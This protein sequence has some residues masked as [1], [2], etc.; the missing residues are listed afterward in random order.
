LGFLSKHRP[1]HKATNCWENH[2]F[3]AVSR[4]NTDQMAKIIIGVMGPGTCTEETRNL[5]Y[6]LGEAIASE[7][8]VTLSGGRNTGVMQAVSRGAR[9][10]G[11]LTLGI[12][13]TEDRSQMNEYVDIPIVSGMGSARNN[14]NVLTPDVVVACGLGAGTVSEIALAM[15]ADK[16][17][18]L[19]SV[20]KEAYRFFQKIDTRDVLIRADKVEEVISLIHRRLNLKK[21]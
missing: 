14:I 19:L 5:A 13:P 6:A 9:Q 8:W 2:Y 11:G 17:V 16:P 18:I 20:E 3:E 1:L 10:A 4:Q 21:N 7:G 15:K 12:L